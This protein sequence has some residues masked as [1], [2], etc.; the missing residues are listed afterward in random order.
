MSGEGQYTE[1]RFPMINRSRI[2][3]GF[4]NL[5]L[6]FIPMNLQRWVIR[7]SNRLFKNSLISKDSWISVFER[8]MN[9]QGIMNFER[10][11]NLKRLMNLQGL[12]NLKG[13]N[14]EK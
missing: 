3:V 14:L 8:F 4:V 7:I 10:F 2:V 6:R 13:L 12:M 11:I 5:S 1:V 9:L